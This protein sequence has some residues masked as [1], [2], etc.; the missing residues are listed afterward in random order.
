METVPKKRGRPPKNKASVPVGVRGEGQQQRL[1]VPQPPPPQQQVPSFSPEPANE[2]A[3]KYSAL[4]QAASWI[5]TPRVC[6]NT[7]EALLLGGH[8]SSL[9]ALFVRCVCRECLAQSSSGVYTC[10]YVC[11]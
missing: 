9:E 3:Q 2:T 5:H 7:R 6:L 8:I 1:Q 4:M 11:L 10:V